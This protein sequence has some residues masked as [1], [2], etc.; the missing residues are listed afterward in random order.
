M[1]KRN[2]AV[3]T[4]IFL[5]L[6]LPG[7]WVDAQKELQKVDA[8]QQSHGK[9]TERN[10]LTEVAPV[11][12]DSAE[13]IPADIPD[14]TSEQISEEIYWDSVELLA[15]CVEAE[16]G[17]QGID[18]KRLVAD[19]ILNRVDDK[20]GMWPD[21]IPEVIAQL[22]QFTSYWDGGMEGVWEVSEETYEAVLMELEQRSYPGLCYFREGEW[23]EYGR[24]WRK[25]G[26]HYF[27]TR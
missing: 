14:M 19:V 11:Q 15:I 21:T 6:M 25:V 18:G 26:D 3:I 13:M 23:P 24:R 20:S 17:N 9:R 10:G 16:A 5:I 8:G 2:T 22:N 7:L 12:Q 1:R 4:V 27:N